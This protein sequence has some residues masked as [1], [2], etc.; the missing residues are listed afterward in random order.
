MP[1]ITCVWWLSTSILWYLSHPCCFSPVLLD[2]PAAWLQ[3][4]AL[5]ITSLWLCFFSG[6][7]SDLGTLRQTK[8]GTEQA[9][10]GAS[11][12]R[13]GCGV[14]CLCGDCLGT[15]SGLEKYDLCLKTFFLGIK[16]MLW[17]MWLGCSLVHSAEF[18]SDSLCSSFELTVQIW[19]TVQCNEK[20]RRICPVISLLFAT[21]SHFHIDG[22]ALGISKHVFLKLTKEKEFHMQFLLRFLAS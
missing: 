16:N 6:A 5:S 17:K 21:F 7:G 14:I 15:G 9:I 10:G 19:A 22:R 2:P 13:V 1:S 20:Q 18:L 11:F 8:Q 3:D 12:L 4:S